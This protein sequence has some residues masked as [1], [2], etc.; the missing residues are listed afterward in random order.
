MWGAGRVFL[1]AALDHATGTVIGRESISEKTNEIPHFAALMGKIGDLGGVVVT[2]DAPHTQQSPKSPT[3]SSTD[4]AKAR[5][6][7]TPARNCG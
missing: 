7:W 5:N 4:F 2:A 6:L 3:D 1:F